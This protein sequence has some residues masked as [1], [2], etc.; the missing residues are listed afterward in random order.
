MDYS[1]SGSV[2]GTKGAPRPKRMKTKGA[3]PPKADQKAELL[4]RMKAAAKAK[5]AQ[6]KG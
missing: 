1:K 4:A 5:E 3:P 2:P 6:P